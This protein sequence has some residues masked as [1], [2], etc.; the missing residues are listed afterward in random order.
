MDDAERR[1]GISDVYIM[2]SCM[3]LPLGGRGM[4]VPERRRAIVYPIFLYCSKPGRG[5]NGDLSFP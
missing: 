1:W 5:G 2:E 4:D 3:A